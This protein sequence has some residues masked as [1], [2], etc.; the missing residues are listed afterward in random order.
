MRRAKTQQMEK[1]RRKRGERDGEKERGQG[2]KNAIMHVS[3][4]NPVL[5]LQMKP[6]INMNKLHMTLCH[7]LFKGTNR[8]GE[9]MCENISTIMA[10]SMGIKIARRNKINGLSSPSKLLHKNRHFDSLLLFIDIKPRRKDISTDPRSICLH[11]HQSM[12]GYKGCF[13]TIWSPS[14]YRENDCSQLENNQESY[15]SSQE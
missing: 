2:T 12:K 5:K 7:Y 6:R 10:V 13:Q 9:V 15:Q 1:E 8:N 3:G 14:S 4:C 11:A